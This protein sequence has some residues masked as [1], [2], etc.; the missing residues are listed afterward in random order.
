MPQF[1][2]HLLGLVVALFALAASAEFHTF[3]IEQIYSNQDGTV[4]CIV[5]HESA[6]MNGENFWGGQNLTATHNGVTKTFTF[7]FD[8]PGGGG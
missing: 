5:M 3:K 4:Q 2:R 1:F 6:G 7:P 8:L